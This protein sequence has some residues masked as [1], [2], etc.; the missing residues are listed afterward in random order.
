MLLCLSLSLFMWHV[1]LIWYHFH[2]LYF[3]II[4][5]SMAGMQSCAVK[6][7]CSRDHQYEKHH[8]R[9]WEW[10]CSEDLCCVFLDTPK[11]NVKKQD[12]PV[13]NSWYAEVGL[14]EMSTSSPNDSSVS[15]QGNVMWCNGQGR[16]YGDSL[17]FHLQLLFIS[18]SYFSAKILTYCDVKVAWYFLAVKCIFWLYLI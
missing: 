3:V 15:E 4:S 11:R 12:Q 17:G 2:R 1:C 16:S 6:L 10:Y 13:S 8:V 5:L 14:W 9:S 7:M 18:M